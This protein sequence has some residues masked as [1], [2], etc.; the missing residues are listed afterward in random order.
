MSAA[1]HGFA[2]G[3]NQHGSTAGDSIYNAVVSKGDALDSSLS[4]SE[5]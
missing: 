1:K 2:E 5:R 4:M 3:G